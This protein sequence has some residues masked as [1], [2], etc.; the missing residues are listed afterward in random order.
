MVWVVEA[1]DLDEGRLAFALEPDSDPELT[2]DDEGVISAKG[3]LSYRDRYSATVTVSD[4][5]HSVSAAFA[6]FTR[7]AS[8]FPRFT[9]ISTSAI[10]AD[11]PN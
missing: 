2:V 10:Q 1:V 9:F 5:L 11:Y 4:G 7:P 8:L 3:P 6:F